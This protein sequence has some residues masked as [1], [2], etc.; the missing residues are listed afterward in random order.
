MMNLSREESAIYQASWRKEAA[1]VYDQNRQ[2]NGRVN[3]E[4]AK[5]T[6]CPAAVRHSV[7]R[8]DP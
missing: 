7:R 5:N 2:R 1:P 8:G 3:C 4:W 6:T